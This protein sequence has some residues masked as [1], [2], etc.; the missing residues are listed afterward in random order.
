MG[1]L[2][3]VVLVIMPLMI[4]PLMIM[5]VTM[6]VRMGMRVPRAVRVEMIVIVLERRLGSVVHQSHRFRRRGL[7]RLHGEEAIE[8][9]MNASR[10]PDLV[11][12]RD[13]GSEENPDIRTEA[14]H[15]LGIPVGVLVIDTLAR[16]FGAGDPDKTQDMTAFVGGLDAIRLAGASHEDGTN[17]K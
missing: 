17:R 1:V 2:V 16:N 9:L 15:A 4:M 5:A 3:M 6:R 8:P 11:A 12:A 13:E 10:D 7:Q 14:V